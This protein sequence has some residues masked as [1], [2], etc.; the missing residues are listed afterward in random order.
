VLFNAAEINRVAAHGATLTKNE[1]KAATAS[2]AM[3]TLPP[4]AA[5]ECA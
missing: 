5:P 4:P 3:S 1:K 2:G